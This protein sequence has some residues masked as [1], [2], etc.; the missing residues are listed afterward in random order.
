MRVLIVHGGAGRWP[1]PE[2]PRPG[3]LAA[4]RAGCDALRRGGSA[5]GA[6]LAAVRVMEDNP[7]FNCGRG[8][9]LTIDRRIE[10]DAAVMTSDGRFGAVAVL[11]GIR[12]PIDVA[13]K[14]MTETSH[15]LIA[16]RGANKLA[17][18]W[19]FRREDLMTA[20]ARDRLARLMAQGGPPQMP[21]FDRYRALDTVGAV[22]LDSRG[23]FAVANSTGGTAGKLPGRVGDTPIYGAGTW[24]CPDG[25]ATATG[26]GEEIIRTFLSKAVCDLMKRHSAQAAIRRALVGLKRAGVIAIDRQG[27]VGHGQ[28]TPHMPWA[29]VQGHRERM[30]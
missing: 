13:Y 2:Q 30:Y 7:V 28:T 4:L 1:D 21:E 8:S 24:A 22:A 23:R 18:F 5:L 9:Q 10:T 19:G 16:G 29:Y 25:A 11:S 26:I 20:K 14:V 3:R 27:R 6:V 15:L 12:H 17:R